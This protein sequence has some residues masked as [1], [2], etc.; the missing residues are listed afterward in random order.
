[1]CD[2]DLISIVP[3]RAE[4]LRF[5]P[6]GEMGIDVRVTHLENLGATKIGRQYILK[7]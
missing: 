1:V 2:L 3:F 7:H 5:E 4:N 6:G